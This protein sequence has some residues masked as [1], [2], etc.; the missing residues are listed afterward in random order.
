M[1]WSGPVKKRDASN[2]SFRVLALLLFLAIAVLVAYAMD[3]AFLAERIFSLKESSDSRFETVQADKFTYG[4]DDLIDFGSIPNP[5]NAY[6]RLKLRFRSDELHGS[7]RIFRSATSDAGVRVEVV[8]STVAVFIPEKPSVSPGLRKM[9]LTSTLD[10]GRWHVLEL[11]AMNGAFI[12]ANLDGRPVMLYGGSEI[13][14][15]TSRFY[16]GDNADPG[17]PFKG[18]LADLYLIKGN[19]ASPPSRAISLAFA[20]GAVLAVVFLIVLWPALGEWDAVRTLIAKLALLALP[21]VAILGYFEYQ[22]SFLNTD[23]FYRRIAFESQ[24][25]KIEVLVSG[26]SNTLYGVNTDQFSRHHGFNL[27]FP[28]HGMFYDAQMVRKFSQRMPALRMVV[29]TVNFFTLGTADAE[30]AQGWRA[31]FDRQYFGL[32]TNGGEGAIGALKFWFEPNNFSKI[33][34]FGALI[35]TQAIQDFKPPVDIV[36]S[37]SGWFDAG[38][39]SVDPALQLGREAA[40]THSS[41]T[42]EK[43]YAPNLQYWDE[44]I[45]DLKRRKIAVVIMQLP[46]DVSYQEW[47]DPKKVATMRKTLEDFATRH[48][49]RYAD[50]TSDPRFSSRDFS[51]ELVDHMNATGANKF[52]RIFNEEVV[53]PELR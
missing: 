17:R 32:P 16:L 19:L 33:A 37:P 30:F 22:L 53:Q 24:I 52:G 5:I 51:W 21:L 47:L 23:Y 38:T 12:R 48:G 29:L 44:L 2:Y 28:G 20:G 41:G 8:D 3:A 7:A 10:I 45:D 26:S 1:E 25:E 4:T 34:L 14:I 35:E 27:A 31:Y 13:S 43:N 36:A 9:L 50:Y 39:V 6:F 15:E 40:N 11:E 42:S 46:T 49:I 18:E